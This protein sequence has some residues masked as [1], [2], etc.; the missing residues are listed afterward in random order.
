TM[1]AGNGG[2]DLVVANV[3]ASTQATVVHDD[4]PIGGVAWMPDG[5]TLMY[6]TGGGGGGGAGGGPIQHLSSPP[7]IG[8]K[9]IFV[10]TEGGRGGGPAASF[11][12]PATGG[13]PKPVAAGA[14][15][16]GGGGGGRGG[17]GGIW[18]DNTHQLSTRTSNG[19]KT[20]TTEAIDISGAAPKVLHEETQ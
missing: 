6:T 11:T 10:A 15:G 17:G 9:L 2:T 4:G 5:A 19:G 16:R 8:A 13:A 7:E 3:A 14:A 18:L 1:S 12:V 20:R